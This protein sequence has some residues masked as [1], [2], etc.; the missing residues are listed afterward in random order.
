MLQV[1]PLPWIY[2][3]QMAEQGKSETENLTGNGNNDDNKNNVKQEG[4]LLSLYS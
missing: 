1:C 3:V 4:S 2:K